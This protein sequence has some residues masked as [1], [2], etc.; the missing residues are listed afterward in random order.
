MKP[1]ARCCIWAGIAVLD[2]F[3]P[4]MVVSEP[5]YALGG[6]YPTALLAPLKKHEALFRSWV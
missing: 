1:E 2:I 6:L 5:S 3:L 4:A